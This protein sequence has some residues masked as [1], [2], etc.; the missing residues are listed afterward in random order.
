MSYV[1]DEL[2]S[3]RYHTAILS[4][5]SLPENKVLTNKD[6]HF[7]DHLTD[8]FNPSQWVY[9]NVHS[10]AP[11]VIFY[12]PQ[13]SSLR[14]ALI[15]HLTVEDITLILFAVEEHLWQWLD[16]NSSLTIATLILQPVIQI[17][18]LIARSHTYVGIQSILVRCR[19]IDL[20]SI[21]RLSRCYRK[22]DGVFDD[23]TRLLIKLV[24]DQSNRFKPVNKTGV[25]QEIM[26]NV[27]P[28]VSSIFP[29]HCSSSNRLNILVKHQQH[30]HNINRHSYTL[31]QTLT[32]ECSSLK[33]SCETN[34]ALAD[35]LKINYDLIAQEFWSIKQIVD[36]ALPTSHDGRYIWKINNVRE[37]IVDAES[38][39]Q[40]SIYSPPFYSSPTGYKMCLRLYLNGDSDT[41]N[42]HM[43]LFLIIM[44]N[45]YD[46][47]LHWPFSYEVLFRL[48]DQSTLNNNQRNITA[49]FRP[50][51]RSNCFH[52]PLSA[53]NDGYGIKKFLSLVEFEQ[54][55][56]LYIKDNTMF[57]ETNINFLSERQV[58]SSILHECGSPNDEWHIDTISEDFMNI[59]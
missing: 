44:R 35:G 3:T 36:D 6:E 31:L 30:I 51:I 56:S 14:I 40:K 54:N 29:L 10:N 27:F 26:S 25:H 50:D 52:R 2:S 38:E 59:S 22:I 18:E 55:R 4:A 17:Q 7:V 49:S 45:D 42:T 15:A 39:R 24:S 21:Q 11:I 32:Q 33:V 28:P 12:G 16:L 23:D 43:S 58:M 53:M 34:A 1:V 46:A 8:Q 37:K 9:G 5:E 48:I 19:R 41:R 20:T 13:Y 47:I 57:I